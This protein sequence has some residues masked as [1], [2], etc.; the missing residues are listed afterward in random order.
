MS[1]QPAPYNA[2]GDPPRLLRET[3]VLA[4]ALYLLG[5]LS[6]GQLARKLGV[7]RLECRE[8]VAG[9]LNTAIENASVPLERIKTL[10]TRLSTANARL[11]ALELEREDWHRQVTNEQAAVH[12]LR[13]KTQEYLSE[14]DELRQDLAAERQHVIRL[15]GVAEYARRLAGLIEIADGQVSTIELDRLAAEA[16][17]MEGSR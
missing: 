7:D 2:G 3:N 1:E 12:E 13:N 11:A 10:E 14:A 8:R 15:A 9:F 6:E 16:M 17:G 5:Q 4:I